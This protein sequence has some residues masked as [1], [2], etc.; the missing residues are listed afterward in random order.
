M[1]AESYP[2]LLRVCLWGVGVCAFIVY[3]LLLVT[4]LG[5]AIVELDPAKE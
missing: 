2:H 4:C 1:V 3:I 5:F